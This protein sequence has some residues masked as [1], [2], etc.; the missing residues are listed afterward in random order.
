MK[1]KDKLKQVL[2]SAKSFNADKKAQEAKKIAEEKK[3]ADQ[4]NQNNNEKKEY[5]MKKLSKQVKH[6]LALMKLIGQMR[7]A[8]QKTVMTVEDFTAMVNEYVEVKSETE[9]KAIELTSD[10]SSLL[11]TT[12]SSDIIFSFDEKSEAGSIL[13]LFNRYDLPV[14]G[15]VTIP[16]DNQNVELQ[17]LAETASVTEQT[18]DESLLTLSTSR[19]ALSFKMS[20][21]LQFKSIVDQLAYVE[22][23]ISTAVA[24]GLVEGIINGQGSSPQVDNGY[25][26]SKMGSKMAGIRAKLAAASYTSDANNKDLDTTDGRALMQQMFDAAGPRFSR[27]QAGYVILANRKQ[28]LKISDLVKGAGVTG[29]N[30]SAASSVYVNQYQGVPVIE[31]AFLISNTTASGS[32]VSHTGFVSATA[33]DNDHSSLILLK[34]DQVWYHIG[35]ERLDVN[36]VPATDSYE[37]TLNCQA[38]WNMLCDA[39]NQPGVFLINIGADIA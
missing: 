34:T 3:I 35:G 26:S 14:N 4:L 30:Q 21:S 16:V 5:K 20:R 1:N 37:I 24:K 17:H 15:T 31:C 36:F 19:A 7:A 29:V 39:K 23:L 18:W 13:A 25:S 38:G 33:A 32:G 22:S 2:Q 10:H 11:R 27:S 8:E 28:K 12:Q 6:D 9:Q